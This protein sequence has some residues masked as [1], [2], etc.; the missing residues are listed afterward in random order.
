MEG[1]KNISGG[2]RQR[3]AIA[4]NLITEKSLYIFDEATSN[5]DVESEEIIMKN[6]LKLSETKIVILISHRLHNVINSTEILMLENG[7]IVE[8]D[9]H[10][11]LLTANHS[12]SRLFN[13]QFKLENG[14][15]EGQNA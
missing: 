8:K 13:E 9:T 6:I 15:K 14:Y 5:I 12:Y 1:S 2:Q 3:L 7:V 10:T 11:N 4:I